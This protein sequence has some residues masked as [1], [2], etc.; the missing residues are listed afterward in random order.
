MARK[1]RTAAVAAC[2]A[3]TA[4][5]GGLTVS[6]APAAAASSTASQLLYLYNGPAGGHAWVS[7]Y[8]TGNWY[9]YGWANYDGSGWAVT[10]NHRW[11]GGQVW[12]DVYDSNWTFQYTHSC[13]MQPNTWGLDAYCS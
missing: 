7:G 13:Y 3:I 2:L 11:S 8:D 5:A 1:L 9:N 10:G 6:A 12:F 4:L